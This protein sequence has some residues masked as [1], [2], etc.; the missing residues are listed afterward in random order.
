ME[1]Q[2]ISA[3]DIEVYHEMISTLTYGYLVRDIIESRIDHMN[4]RIRSLL[5]G[6]GKISAE[7]YEK[8]LDEVL[9]LDAERKMYKEK[10]K[11]CE[12][13]FLSGELVG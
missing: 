9:H 12:D 4:K 1:R 2:R 5:D 7:E 6:A 8:A 13:L 10:L 11:A 3:E